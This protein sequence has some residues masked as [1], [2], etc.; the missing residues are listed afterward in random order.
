MNK[1]SINLLFLHQFISCLCDTDMKMLN[2]SEIREFNVIEIPV[3][4]IVMDTV[5]DEIFV[6]G[7]N[8][9]Y[10][11]NVMNEKCQLFCL[12]L[13]RDVVVSDDWLQTC[14]SNL[15]TH[16]DAIYLIPKQHDTSEV[17]SANSSNE[18]EIYNG[19][20][21]TIKHKKYIPRDNFK[22][23]DWIRTVQSMDGKNQLEVPIGRGTYGDFRVIWSGNPNTHL[24]I[25]RF[26]S[27]A[28]DVTVDFYSGRDA[29]YRLV[30]TYNFHTL[31][32]NTDDNEASRRS[33]DKNPCNNGE[34]S[35]VIIGE[36]NLIVLSPHRMHSTV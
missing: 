8:D 25:G 32:S 24:Q 15:I 4:H 34:R 5:R 28:P 20:L 17:V 36:I 9:I 3:K 16:I 7:V 1:I 35:E 11:A 27:I 18:N 22:N 26:C 12:N 14:I 2:I 29:C 33:I 19:I 30:S 13:I 21:P 31:F 6:M 23:D 10:N